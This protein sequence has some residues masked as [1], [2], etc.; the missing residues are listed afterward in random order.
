MLALLT[1]SDWIALVSVV[2]AVLTLAG[3]SGPRIGKRLRNTR[4]LKLEIEGVKGVPGVPDRPSLLDQ[5]DEVK[6][7]Q[8]RL[9]KIAEEALELAKENKR[10]QGQILALLG[11]VRAQ[12]KPAKGG[13]G[14]TGNEDGIDNDINYRE[15]ARGFRE[16]PAS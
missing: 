2:I 10:A 11:R 1:G 5:L 9:R 7:E 4:I 3:F 16:D 15:I 12:I 13:Q 6:E 8:Q 14:A